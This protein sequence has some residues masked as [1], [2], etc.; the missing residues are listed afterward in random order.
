MSEQIPKNSATLREAIEGQTT[1]YTDDYNELIRR[2]KEEPDLRAPVLDTT[3]LWTPVK[4]LSGQDIPPYS[5][6]GAH[7][8]PR[9]IDDPNILDIDIMARSTPWSIFTNSEFGIITNSHGHACQL[10]LWKPYK[11]AVK[12]G[13]VPRIGEHCGPDP[14]GF[15]LSKEFSGLV[16]QSVVFTEGDQQ[17]VWASKVNHSSVIVQAL[18]CAEDAYTTEYRF[19]VCSV[20]NGELVVTESTLL[21]RVFE[22]IEP[23]TVCEATHLANAGVFAVNLLSA[24]ASCSE[25]E[26]ESDSDSDSESGSESEDSGSDDS[27]DCV[28]IPILDEQDLQDML[29]EPGDRVLIKK[30]DGCWAFGMFMPC[31][32][33]EDS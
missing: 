30:P 26:S 13:S 3:K 6:F 4:N 10:D 27:D 31:T 33:V 22:T 7:N 29:I 17:L 11:L 19:A 1:I 14:N 5:L 15:S 20:V 24:D 21:A 32:E 28:R 25:S 23:G 18:E 16:C 8:R 12:P 2:A 9:F